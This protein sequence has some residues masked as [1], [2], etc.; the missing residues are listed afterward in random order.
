MRRTRTAIAYFILTAL[1]YVLA[2]TSC[3]A[4]S[5]VTGLEKQIG[6]SS[7]QQT[8]RQKRVARLPRA[9]ALRLNGIFEKLIRA[10]WRH[11][12][13]NYTLTVIT[14]E[15]INAFALPGG[16]ILINT[17]LLDFA[18]TDGEIAGVLAH[19]IAHVE[20]KHGINAVS[21][22]IG[23]TLL[24]DLLANRTRDPE[25]SVQL[26]AIAIT[27]VQRGY[28]REA[29]YQA[30]A[31]GVRFMTASGYSKQAMIGFFKKLQ[32]KYGSNTNYPA[33]QL[34]NT[35][36]PTDKRIKRIEMM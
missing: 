30:D 33:L 19:E 24:L 14:D 23:F 25:K 4:A 29:E 3:N 26:G 28:S 36:P 15:S 9:Q 12:E 5:F 17:G 7:Y 31:Y 34:L 22:A 16:Y 21:R 18:K 27:L 2:L 8:I 10:G 13:L 1:I 35:H 11:D 6:Y 20:C 32:N